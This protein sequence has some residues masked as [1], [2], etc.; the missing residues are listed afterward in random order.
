MVYLCRMHTGYSRIDLS[1]GKIM[2]IRLIQ[3]LIILIALAYISACSNNNSNNVITKKTT[4]KHRV[5]AKP[6][7]NK[8]EKAEYASLLE[9][10]DKEVLAAPA[11]VIIKPKTVLAA[12]KKVVKRIQKARPVA[13]KKYIAKQPTTNRYKTPSYKAPVNNI[14]YA[15]LSGDYVNNQQ[16]HNFINKMSTKY[17]FDRGYLNYLLSNTKAT[18]FLKKMAYK[19]AF[20]SRKSTKN[21]K[22]RSGRWNR[23][24]DNFLTERTISKGLQF[25]KNNRLALQRAEQMYG[26]PQEY[27]LGIIGVETRYGG[28]VG[29]NR[30]IDA[31]AAM[32]FN[33]PRRG[34]YFTSELEAYLLMTRKERLDPL[35]PM[36]SYAGALGLSQFMP[37]NIKRYAVDHDRSGS[38]NLWTP[39]DAIGSVANYFKRHGWKTGG[40]VA[41]PA[42]SKNSHYKTLKT[43]FKSKHSLTRLKNKGVSANQLG[44]ISGKASLIK[45][46][47]YSGD[48]LWLGGHNFYVITRYN[49]SS[50]YAMAVHQLAEAIDQRIGGRS[51][52]RQASVD[53]T[54]QSI[55]NMY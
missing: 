24:R 18:P 14:R 31:L 34:K 33:N 32:G 20:G 7:I 8:K 51:Q 2:S 19:D 40:T 17:G 21:R 41:V 52:I 15:S 53:N 43:G 5:E 3:S 1:K 27:I 22:P 50:H 29:K 28:N 42:V 23:Y 36:A 12:K 37:S 48:E 54:Y 55:I 46:N 38:V 44:N 30:A 47:T 25:W 4:I 16:A 39:H 49:H 13:K 45:L 10:W 35:K 26:V 6:I 9:Q 11:K